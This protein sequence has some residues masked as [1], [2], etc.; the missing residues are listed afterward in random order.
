MM[1]DAEQYWSK[2][3]LYARRALGD[4]LDD[5]ER[6]FWSALS[7]EFLARSS[8]ATI[9][10]V[11]N[12][13][14]RDER[15][16]FYAFGYE[17]KGQ[18]RSLPVHAVLGRIEKL[19]PQFD[20]PTK[21]FCD[22]FV[23]VRNRELHTSELAFEGLAES[24]WLPR[25]YR[26]SHILCQYLGHELSDLLGD[27]TTTTAERLIEALDSGKRSEVLKSIA[28]HRAVFEAKSEPERERLAAD[29]EVLSA[30]WTG[31]SERVTCPSCGSPAK[32]TGELERVS[33]PMFDGASLWVEET[34]LATRMACGA[35][36]LPLRDIQEILH[37][38]LEPHFT[39]AEETD[40]HA[41][42]EPEYYDEYNNM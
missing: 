4:G 30:T 18:P 28:A 1:W 12:A 19:V 35:C 15:N 34:Y 10:P 39:K 3:R 2:A 24:E 13:D 21:D 7:L 38:G 23:M 32:L 29:Q 42:F 26:A 25:Y 33:E 14:P 27:D 20:K 17:I 36:D 37:A 5:W 22:F 40:L 31:A 8:L 41:Y 6:A 11:L 16:L 9:H